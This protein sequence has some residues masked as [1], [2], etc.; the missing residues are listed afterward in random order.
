MLVSHLLTFLKSLKVLVIFKMTDFMS[1]LSSIHT[2]TEKKYD[3]VK[4]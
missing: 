2:E 4:W 3:F 1:S